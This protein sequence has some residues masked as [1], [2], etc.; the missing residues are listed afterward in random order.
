MECFIRCQTL[1]SNMSNTRRASVSS[2]IQTRRSDITNTRRSVS[3]DIQTLR[4]NISNNNQSINQSINNR[5]SIWHPNT[6]KCNGKNGVQSNFLTPTFYC[7]FYKH[8]NTKLKRQLTIAFFA[9]VNHL[10]GPLR[11]QNFTLTGSKGHS[12]YWPGLNCLYQ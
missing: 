6:E 4:S 5:Q 3:S 8:A 2:D 11:K 12:V 10:N 7:S 9:A 1:R